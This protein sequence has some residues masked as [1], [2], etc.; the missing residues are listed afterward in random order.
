MAE[1][2]VQNHIRTVELWKVFGELQL[3]M[4]DSDSLEKV[5]E[6]NI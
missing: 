1:M 6:W 4:R 5:F 3:V 2:V